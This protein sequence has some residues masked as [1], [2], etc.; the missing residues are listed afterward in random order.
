[1][2]LTV[3]KE[4]IDLLAINNYVN[5]RIFKVDGPNL[6]S[7][8]ELEIVNGCA[9]YLHALI[10]LEQQVKKKIDKSKMEVVFKTI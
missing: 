7:E 8:T 1:M 2:S 5:E 9:S 10:T 4:W 6:D 3:K